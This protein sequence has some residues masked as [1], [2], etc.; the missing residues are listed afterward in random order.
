MLGKVYR[1]K[2]LCHSSVSGRYKIPRVISFFCVVFPS[3]A[4]KVIFCAIP[5]I[6][7]SSHYFADKIHCALRAHRYHWTPKH[8]A[9]RILSNSDRDFIYLR[10]S[11]RWEFF[12]VC[13]A[14]LSAFRKADSFPSESWIIGWDEAGMQWFSRRLVGM[15]ESNL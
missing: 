13:F 15:R 3:H 10:L 1:V 14:F 2:W 7:V 8:R 9:D 11:R 12:M 4:W 5:V 6:C